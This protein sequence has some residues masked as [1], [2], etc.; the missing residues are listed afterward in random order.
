[1]KRSEKQSARG[2]R[3]GIFTTSMPTSGRTASNDA[4]N[5]PAQSR[6][7]NRN[8]A[9]CSP[10]SM[11]RLRACCVVRGPS[12]Y[13]SRPSTCRWRVADLKHEQD[14]ET[15][16][17]TEQSTWKKST[18]HTFVGPSCARSRRPEPSFGSVPN[19]TPARRLAAADLPGNRTLPHAMPTPFGSCL[20]ESRALVR[21]A[22]P[23][24]R[25]SHWER[26]R[27]RWGLPSRHSLPGRRRRIDRAG[28]NQ[29]AW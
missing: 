2:H 16:Q 23:G 24:H 11:T 26:Q 19:P 6:T 28:R 20:R 17:V 13:R 14:V 9:A 7:R 25:R 5:C 22:I 21:C 1:M 10:R 15:P 18:T 27:C 3:G 8:R 12:R 29:R 4:V